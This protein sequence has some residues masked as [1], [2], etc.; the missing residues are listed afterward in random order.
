MRSGRAT[1]AALAALWVLA[2][3][4]AAACTKN[5]PNYCPDAG[6][7]GFNCAYAADAHFP[8]AQDGNRP[9]ERPEVADASDAGDASDASDASDAAD[10]EAGE[11]G[12]AAADQVDVPPEVAPVCQ[13]DMDCASKDAGTAACVTPD[14]GA[15]MCVGCTDSTKHCAGTAR[16][17]C[18]TAAQKCVECV[19]STDCLT[20]AKPVCDAATSTCRPCAADVECQGNGPGICVDWDG[21]C[22]KPDEIETLQGGAACVAAPTSFA[23]CQSAAA[24]A[25]L[26]S[27]PILLVKGPDPVAAIDVP[28]GA[29]PKILIVGQGG[30]TIG[31]GLGDTAGLHLPGATRY[32]VRGFKISGGTTGVVADTGAELHLTRCVVTKNDK[33]GIKAVGASFDITNT[34]VAAN[35]SGSDAMGLVFGGVRL[36]VTA[37]GATSKFV[38]NTVVDNLQVGISCADSSYDVSTCVIH[39]NTGSDAANCAGFGPG[40]MC[41]ATADPGLDANYRLTA[42]SSCIDR[43]TANAMTP[44]TDIDGDPRPTGAGKLD[45][46]ADEH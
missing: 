13:Q 10:G 19:A 8:D 12:D 29:A 6:A 40:Q 31:A 5:N 30:A 11:V 38:N 4:G 20:T 33:G 27:R 2:A 24:A 36:G 44:A 32:W 18:D 16:P 41:C 28:T 22:A 3:L 45:C 7:F 14:G 26:A 9:E 35:G 17:V 15:A 34:I 25:A 1:P 42:T 23:F 43:L 21:H 37:M 46:G 39:G